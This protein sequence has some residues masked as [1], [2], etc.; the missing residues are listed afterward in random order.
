MASKRKASQKL[1]KV[2]K[3][4]PRAKKRAAPAAK[5]KVEQRVIGGIMVD[6]VEKKYDAKYVGSYS[7][8]GIGDGPYLVFWRE[9]L[10]EHE[11]KN[12]FD[13]YFGIWRRPL[14][15]DSVLIFNAKKI[16]DAVFPAI[17]LEPG[18][19]LCSRSVH[20]FVTAPN[21][22]GFLDGGPFYTRH[23][24]DYPPT[25]S[26]AIVDGK[27]VFT[28]LT[29][30][31]PAPAEIVQAAPREALVET[32]EPTL[33]VDFVKM[34]QQACLGNSARDLKRHYGK[35]FQNGAADIMYDVGRFH[36]ACDQPVR[37]VPMMPSQDEIDFRIRLIDEEFTELKDA[38][39]DGDIVEVA[40][41]LCDIMY[42]VAGACHHFGIQLHR[43]WAEVQASN[44]AK[45]DPVTG[46]VRKRADG[47]VLKPE[48]WQPPN[49]RRALGLET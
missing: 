47:K 8:P 36:V 12:G 13:N 7:I 22:N 2:A 48:G 42:V 9:T 11:T 19:F 46:K 14:R 28:P 40:D 21:G 29:Q 35:W 25:H 17:E 32:A 24:P 44:M 33:P 5:P 1:N 18:R 23:N 20:D 49:V 38:C 6:A 31:P 30:A 10:N 37:Y 3:T 43:V 39:A 4:K 15:D 26:M 45:I 27:E 34:L 16:R 41:A